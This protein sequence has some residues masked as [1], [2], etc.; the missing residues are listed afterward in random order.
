[1]WSGN[2]EWCGEEFGKFEVVRGAG[3]EPAT[4]GFGD[5]HSIQLS[6]PRADRGLN[7]AARPADGKHVFS[8]AKFSDRDESLTQ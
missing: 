1:M 6:Y 2:V 3:V 8:T 4:C 7:Y 5:R